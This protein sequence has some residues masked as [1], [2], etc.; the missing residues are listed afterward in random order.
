[1]ISAVNKRVKM[2]HTK[3]GI[4]V[5]K[6][7]RKDLAID[8]ENGDNVWSDAIKKEMRN[9]APAFK[10]KA[11]DKCIGNEY[12]YARFHMVYD[13]KMDFTQKARLVADGHQVPDPA[14]STY[15][16]VV[17]RE[18]VRIELIYAA[19]MELDIMAADM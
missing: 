15:S 19:L 13:I 8:Q 1:M 14:V 12:K 18:S 4:R 17:S 10:L 2:T 6:T 5:P 7:R 3:Y 11:N 9:V 16:G